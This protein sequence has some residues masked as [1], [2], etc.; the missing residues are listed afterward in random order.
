VFLLACGGRTSL[1]TSGTS[2]V[3]DAQAPPA[4]ASTAYDVI[5]ARQF[6]TL[7]R[8]RSEDG[9]VSVW[10]ASGSVGGI[11][12]TYDGNFIAVARKG[13]SAEVLDRN[14]VTVRVQDGWLRAIRPD[15]QRLM[16]AREIE[17]KTCVGTLDADGTFAN[18]RCFTAAAEAY[19]VPI[20]YAP[21]GHTVLW[22]HDVYDPVTTG[23][24][25]SLVLAAEDGSGARE[26]VPADES[27][28]VSSVH[29][30]FD[31]SRVTFLS[32]TPNYD[33]V[34]CDVDAVELSTLARRTLL[35]EQPEEWTGAAQL[36]PD[37]TQA[38]FSIGDQTKP[39]WASPDGSALDV[40]D[41]S[42]SAV[43]TLVSDAHFDPAPPVAFCVVRE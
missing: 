10:N 36:V 19:D 21:D 25:V 16:V 8:W 14:G 24:R 41:L 39:S 15:G 3:T 20:A 30:S 33:E 13:F 32:C 17:S 34:S 6:D 5:Y 42:T 1:T 35:H 26:I 40:V 37:G 18:E 43:A 28:R 27:K 9:S 4:T 12:C 38:I 11:A 29:F 7:V 2:P 31:G 22:E 23:T